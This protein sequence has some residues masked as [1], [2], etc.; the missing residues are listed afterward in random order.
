M[1]CTGSKAS[2]ITEN[3]KNKPIESE[4]KIPINE[5]ETK[6]VRESWKEM[7]KLED[8]KKH[9]TLMMIK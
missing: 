4:S 5:N 8:F 7:T 1:G 2:N 3:Q 9:G 6:L